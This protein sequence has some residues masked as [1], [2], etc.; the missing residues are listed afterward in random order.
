MET[1]KLKNKIVITRVANDGKLQYS[2]QYLTR[3]AIFLSLNSTN[4]VLHSSSNE[5]LNST[6]E[7]LGSTSEL[8]GSRKESLNNRSEAL[9]GTSV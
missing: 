2:D 3:E 6:S 5:S 9:N 4:E 1:E 8:L 7:L